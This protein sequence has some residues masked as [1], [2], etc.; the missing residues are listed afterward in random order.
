MSLGVLAEENLIGGVEI[1]SLDLF[2]FPVT[3]G[4]LTP[5]QPTHTSFVA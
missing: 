3:S 1:G 2:F 5:Q 4:F